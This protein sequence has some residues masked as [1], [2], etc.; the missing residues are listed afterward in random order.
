MLRG[1]GF[2][3]DTSLQLI[4]ET[5]VGSRVAVSGFVPQANVIPA[6]R[7]TFQV[8]PPAGRRT[9]TPTPAIP[10]D[11]LRDSVLNR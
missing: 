10:A 6:L 5:S 11:P 4:W 3:P 7:F 1:E 8:T 9:T 2:P